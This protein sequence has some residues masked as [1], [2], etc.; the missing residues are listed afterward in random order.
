M[1]RASEPQDRRLGTTAAT[2]LVVA[3]MVGTGIFTTTGF[4]AANVA[5]PI[6]ILVVWAAGGVLALC[7]AS[8]YGELGA[9]MP[10]AGGEYVYLRRAFGPAVGFLSGFVSL[11]VG[12]SAPIAAAAYGFGAYLHSAVPSVP[13]LGAAVGVIVL[14]T[15]LHMA[16]VVWGG[17]VQT[18]LSAYK[19]LVIVAFVAAAFTVGEGDMAHLVAEPLVVAPSELAVALVLVAFAYSGWNAA[20]YVAGEL[21]DPGRTLPRSLLLGAGSVALLYLAL[22]VAFFYGAPSAVLAASPEDVGAVAARALFGRAGDLFAL[23]IAFALVSSVSA[24]VLAGPRVYLAMARDGVFFRARADEPAGRA[25]RR[26]GLAGRHRG[27]G[28]GHGELRRAAHLDRVH[29]VAV[30]RFDGGRSLR[31]QAPRAACGAALPH[32]ALA[33]SAAVVP[34]AVPLDGG[35][36]DPRRAPGGRSRSRHAGRRPLVPRRVAAARGGMSQRN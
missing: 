34:R 28:G 10:H 35:V 22:N 36:L 27:R 21:R 15:A 7:G 33:R 14:T 12:F 30:R 26:G 25:L 11:V 3:N 13:L 19:V 20:A 17:R 31:A 4:M 23:A 32:A 6:L 29:V 2:A 16:D 8:V 1:T 9:M 18:L 24:M 5:N